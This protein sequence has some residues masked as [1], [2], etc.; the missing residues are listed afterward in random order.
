[1]WF[2]RQYLWGEAEKQSFGFGVAPI[3]LE[4][5]SFLLEVPP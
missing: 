2:T 4:G 1:M 3:T 5:W